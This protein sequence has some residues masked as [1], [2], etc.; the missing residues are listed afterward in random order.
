MRRTLVWIV[1]CQILFVGF[2]MA[3]PVVV[4]RYANENCTAAA[5]R[6]GSDRRSP[7]AATCRLKAPQEVE[8]D[9]R[10]IPLPR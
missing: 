8:A 7:H 9:Y 6:I 5:D 4:M 2:T 10:L 1:V 3:G